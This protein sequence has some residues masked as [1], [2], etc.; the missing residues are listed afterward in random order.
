MLIGEILT[1]LFGITNEEIEKA[2]EVQ[3]KVGGRWAPSPRP[4]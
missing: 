2:L 3:K 4:S 1:S